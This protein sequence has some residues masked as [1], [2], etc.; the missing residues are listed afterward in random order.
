MPMMNGQK[1][2]RCCGI[3]SLV[4]GALVLA[5]AFLWP[6]W[7]GVDGWVTFFGL[8]LV[9]SGFIK[10]VVPDKCP[11]CN[12]MACDMKPAGKGKK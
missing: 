8:L 10:L 3:C 4:V 6:K 12:A 2:K 1:C 11:G 9:L 5:N 7:V